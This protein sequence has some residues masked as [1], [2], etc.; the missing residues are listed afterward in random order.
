MAK[1][2]HDNPNHWSDIVGMPDSVDEENI[3]TI[4]NNFR[5]QK[6]SFTDKQGNTQVISGE[7]W[8]VL[9]I[10]DAKR[11]HDQE[12]NVWNPKNIKIKET[13]MRALLAMPPPLD[14]IISEAYPTMFRDKKHTLRFAKKFPQFMIA[15]EL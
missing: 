7:R 2:L 5:R 6:F 3:R 15:Q 9:A 8:I 11:S 1:R 13:E 4:I 12:H 14:A 10:K